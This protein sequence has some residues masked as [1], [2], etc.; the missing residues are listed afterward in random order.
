MHFAPG[1]TITVNRTITFRMM[2]KL[3]KTIR[4]NKNKYVRNSGISSGIGVYSHILISQILQRLRS[5]KNKSKPPKRSFQHTQSPG[6]KAKKRLRG[7][8]A[9]YE[10]GVGELQVCTSVLQGCASKSKA[11][12]IT[13]QISIIPERVVLLPESDMPESKTSRRRAPQFGVGV[14]TPRT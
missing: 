4:V 2:L 6:V 14:V 1:K 10:S 3:E 9:V 12:S 7:F 11:E 13:P 5:L 8:W